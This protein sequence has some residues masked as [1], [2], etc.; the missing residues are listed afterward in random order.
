MKSLLTL[1]DETHLD[2]ITEAPEDFTLID[3]NTTNIIQDRRWTVEVV[4]EVD[5]DEHSEVVVSTNTRINPCL[6]IQR[7]I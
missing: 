5:N 6:S 1:I 4:F 2:F 7:G 3:I